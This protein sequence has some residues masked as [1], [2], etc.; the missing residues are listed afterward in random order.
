VPSPISV[1]AC[2]L[3]RSV[4]GFVRLSLSLAPSPSPSPSLLTHHRLTVSE[5]QVL[6][7]FSHTLQVSSASTQTGEYVTAE[8]LEDVA[9]ECVYNMVQLGDLLSGPQAMDLASIEAQAALIPSEAMVGKSD[10]LLDQLCKQPALLTSSAA[11]VGQ[12]SCR[13]KTVARSHPP[14]QRVNH[15]YTR[16]PPIHACATHTRVHHPYTTTRAR[17]RILCAVC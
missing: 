13:F 7:C 4:T 3:L 5:H 10:G 15:P 17:L 12:T 1:T 6:N 2:I 16:E 8:L 9:A 14:T 11:L